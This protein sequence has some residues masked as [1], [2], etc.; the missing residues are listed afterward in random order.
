MVPQNVFNPSPGN[1]FCD[2]FRGRGKNTPRHISS[3][4]AHSDK[5]P[6][7]Y[8]YVFEVNLSSSGTSDFVGR[9][10]LLEIQDGSQITGISNNFAGFTD[11]RRSKK[12]TWV[13]DYVWNI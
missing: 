9:R 1:G 5:I 7:L 3:S 2:I 4:R 6:T 10:C 8:T 13:Y 12:N 11:T